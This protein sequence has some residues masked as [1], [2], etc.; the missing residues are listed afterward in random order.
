MFC[1]LLVQGGIVGIWS[2]RRKI[3]ISIAYPETIAFSIVS[4]YAIVKV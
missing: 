2:E 1:R 3:V 4:G